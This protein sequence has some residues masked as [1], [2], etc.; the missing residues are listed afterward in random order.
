MKTLSE[1]CD[2]AESRDTYLTTE[3][4]FLQQ[5]RELIPWL[6]AA[7]ILILDMEDVGDDG[8]DEE[9]WVRGLKYAEAVE[10]YDAL[11]ES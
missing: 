10:E 3:R 6:L 4:I 11:M 9:P 7:E 2:T 5:E 1:Q 8:E